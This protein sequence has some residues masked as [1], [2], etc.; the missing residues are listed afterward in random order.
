MVRQ[1][2]AQRQSKRPQAR[3]SIARGKLGGT[4]AGGTAATKKAQSWLKEYPTG[5]QVWVRE[6]PNA[7]WTSQEFTGQDF[8]M[9]EVHPANKKSAEDLTS[10]NY[11]NEPS[12]MNNLEL[13]Y[14]VQSTSTKRME[15]YSYISNVLVA[16]NPFMDGLEDP[17]SED[18]IS[19]AQRAP[20]P[21]ALAEGAFKQMT[22]KADDIG[23]SI[24]KRTPR[25]ENW[26]EQ[27]SGDYV[28]VR[29]H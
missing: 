28:T 16:V 10:L 6:N 3:A 19:G 20:H 23:A 5:D 18:Y 11:I 9:A 14:N 24:D 8:G 26:T 2:K 25:I 13:R 12:I 29:I 1:S 27:G 7:A 21:Y 22:M 17:K 15:M 4:F